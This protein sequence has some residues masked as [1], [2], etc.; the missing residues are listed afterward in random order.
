[1]V[2]GIKNS[3]SEY[4]AIGITFIIEDDND[5]DDDFEDEEEI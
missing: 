5:E 4:I 1:M 3:N 2:V